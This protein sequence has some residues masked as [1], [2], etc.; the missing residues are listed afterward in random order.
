[1]NTDTF[2]VPCVVLNKGAVLLSTNNFS[3][4]SSKKLYLKREIAEEEYF[5]IKYNLSVF[6]FTSYEVISYLKTQV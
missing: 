2:P 1:M 3:Q 6:I 4:D 5:F